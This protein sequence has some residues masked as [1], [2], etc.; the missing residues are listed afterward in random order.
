[1]K[2]FIRFF[3]EAGRLRKVLRRGGVLIGSKSPSS[4]TDHLFRA[5]LMTLVL[6]REKNGNLNM[7]KVLEMALVHD[8]CELYTGDKSPYDHKTIL[9]QDK[10]KWPEL[11]D[12]WPR[13]TAQE[14]K[15][16]V[17]QKYKQEGKAID[18]LLQGLPRAIQK[19]IKGSWSEYEKGLTKEARFVKQINRLEA[20]L[21]ALE[22]GREEKIRV[23]KSWWVGSKER[24]D[25]PVLIKF[26]EALAKEFPARD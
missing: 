3:T 20:L 12:H 24:I 16:R 13:L 8:L 4:I 23:Y 7:T 18:R 25:E 9:P 1:M 14:K 26:M 22:Y 10:K 19:E 5:A 21:Q 2:P 17:E 15:R 11:F 6:G